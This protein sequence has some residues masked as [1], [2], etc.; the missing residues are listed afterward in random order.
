[1]SLPKEPRQK[2]I[3]MMYLVLTALLALNVSSEILN[4]FKT[5]NNSITTSNALIDVKNAQT[6]KNFE[7]ELGDQM[8]K[9][10][11]ELWKPKADKVKS[12]AEETYNFIQS[13]KDSLIQE[14][15]P[16]VKDGVQTF[17][18]ANL[19]AATR[20]MDKNGKG[21]VLYQTLADFKKNVLS[22]INPEEFNENPTLKKSLEQKMEMFKSQ[23]PIDLTIPKGQEGK[24]YSEDAKGWTT[25]Y[26]HMTPTIAALTILSKFQNDV[27]NT[28]AQL[29]DFIHEQVGSVKVVY[30]E[31]EAI[32]Q[33]NTTYA[34]QGDAIEVTAGVGAFSAAAKPRI[35]INGQNIALTG[36][37]AIFKT[38]ASGPGEHTVPVKID[39][40]KPDG[41]IAT[42]T[43][44]VKYTVGVPSGASV[45]LQKM[46]VMYIGVENPITI[47]GGSVGKEKVK[48]S[49][50][51]GTIKSVGGDNWMVIPSG[52]PA[53]SKIVVNADGKN[54]EFPMR[55]KNLP[56]PAGFI[57][58][59]K[60]GSISSAE[61]KAIGGLIARLEDSDFEAP[62]KV[63]SYKLAAI[64]GAVSNYR[65]A[66]NDGNRWTGAA[67]SIVSSAS[68]GTN[69][70]FDEINVVGPD[71][72][73]R[74]IQ[75][76]V[77]TLK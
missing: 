50:A 53:I 19:D 10:K 39:Y 14:S 26:F 43:E 61:F 55:I 17:N 70:F 9:A 54:F 13:L 29:V 24:Q 62:F 72:K 63:V 49:F 33:A 1:M 46:N 4:A 56:N 66:K 25:S 57:G 74:Q 44:N 34:M 12:L 21:P 60:G 67:A 52:S 20:L 22:V 51:N 76:M 35:T 48:V 65:E 8:T 77:F 47:S 64:G 32:A 68:P 11:A 71:G 15:N 5:V 75:P 31:F 59:K 18:E 30:D 2:M 73:P 69:I 45:F 3:N 40:T 36:G 58:T 16:Q 38:T 28:E 6:F 41:T 42:K 7:S 23:I 27:R 37:K